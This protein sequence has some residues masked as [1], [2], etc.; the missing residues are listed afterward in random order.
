LT[1]GE[2]VFEV[3]MLAAIGIELLLCQRGAP[4][5]LR[6]IVPIYRKSVPKPASTSP[7][8]T[9]V[10]DADEARR[11]VFAKLGFRRLS[12]NDVGFWEP[13]RI[14]VFAI[15]VFLAGRIVESPDGQ[16][17]VRAGPRWFIPLVWVWSLLG[18]GPAF[19]TPTPVLLGV[20][21]LIVGILHYIRLGMIAGALAQGSQSV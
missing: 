5:Y 10:D 20:A 9:W 8:E 17:E 19:D 21:I 11:G 12:P 18:P 14:A 4:A 6:S 3:A 13:W 1:H 7:C 2:V 16:L 15:P